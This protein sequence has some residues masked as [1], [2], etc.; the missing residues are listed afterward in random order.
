MTYDNT[1]R[2]ALFKNNNKRNDRD[3][4]YTGTVNIDGIEY[5][6]NGW[7]KEGQKGRFFS[8]TVKAKEQRRQEPT[9]A[10]PRRED[11]IS[12]GRPRNAD[13]NDDIPF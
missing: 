6:L 13:L 11:P 2:F 12:T 8:G 1:N 3:A 5:W 7:V 10:A 9:R 4:E